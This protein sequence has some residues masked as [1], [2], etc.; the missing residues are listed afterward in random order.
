[1]TQ[2]ILVIGAGVSGLSVALGLLQRGHR[3]TVLERSTVGGESSWAG[4]GILSPLLPWDYAEPVSA[5]ALQ[6]MTGYADWV[7]G[8][9]AIS[10]RSAEF[11]RCGMLALNVANPE[12]ALAWCMAHGMMA[13]WD[14]PDTPHL[15]RV[16]PKETLNN[17]TSIIANDVK[18]SSVSAKSKAAGSPRRF[19][20]RDDG[21]VQHVSKENCIW[22]PGI[23]QVRNPRLV[24][25]L[26]A[27]VVQ[28]GGVIREQCPATGVLTQGGRV[29]AV[30][31]AAET[32]PADAV[33]LATGAWSGLGLAGLAATP[34]IRPIRGQML[35]FKLAP[36]VLDTIL[37]RNGLYLIPRRDGH[38]LVGSTLEDAGFDKSTDGA[39]RQR[40]HAEAAELLPALAA[41]QPVRHWAGLR[42]GSPDNIPVIDRHPDFGNVF[43]NTGHYRYGVT[44][45]PASAE[46]LVDLMEGRTP[47]L[48]PTP[49][50]WQA[51]LERRWADGS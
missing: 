36:G 18:Q 19:A 40:L 2:N 31:T 11:W 28:L 44:L 1:M 16:V 30:Q 9:E 5:L 10:G 46:L 38:V 26:R 29:T 23:A 47:V 33:V 21:I 17:T 6:S 41:M 12:Q 20:P 34:Q 45:A 14:C 8:I 7:A 4:G 27:A 39:T 22:L 25:A 3:V 24:A 15:A 50:R 37:Y 35:L 49:Y 43:V 42:P 13:E 32:F 48:D 51:A